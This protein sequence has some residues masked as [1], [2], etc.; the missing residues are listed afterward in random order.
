MQGI[1]KNPYARYY[2]GFSDWLLSKKCLLRKRKKI[3]RLYDNYAKKIY[4]TNR[5][6]LRSSGKP[7]NGYFMDTAA[8]KNVMS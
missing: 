2:N 3:D 5:P 1:K 7:S 8:I 4:G 6:N